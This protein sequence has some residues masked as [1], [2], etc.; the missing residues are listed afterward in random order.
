MILFCYYTTCPNSCGVTRGCTDSRGF[1][2][3]R[4]PHPDAGHGGRGL[5]VC[6]P[7]AVW[8]SCGVWGS[9]WVHG[10]PLHHV[11]VLI[12][13]QRTQHFNLEMKEQVAP[14]CNECLEKWVLRV[15]CPV[16]VLNWFIFVLASLFFIYFACFCF[17][18]D[19]H[20]AVVM[21]QLN[22]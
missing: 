19:I 5:P 22:A 11:S 14:F 15:F 16:F 7:P 4:L 8:D 18:L 10:P 12:Y 6:L 2:P 1:L 9:G 3:G 13:I 20:H 21:M 17:T